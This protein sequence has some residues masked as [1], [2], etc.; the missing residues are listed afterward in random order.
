MNYEITIFNSPLF[1]AL[2]TSVNESGEPFFC[3]S[4]VCKVLNLQAG[5]TK[6]RLD[7]KGIN[8]INTLTDG[9]SQSMVYV[10]EPNLY[11]C[12]F[13]S[14]K[15][16][17]EMFQRWVFEEV[18]PSLRKNGGYMVAKLE[19][20]P[21]EIM[22]RALKIADEALLRRE[23]RIKEL[24]ADNDIKAQM[25]TAQTQELKGAAP[26]V[27]FYDDTLASV[28]YI[29]TS[30][31]ANELGMNTDTLNKK[32]ADAGIQHKQGKAW[33]VNKPYKNW[34]LHGTRT[35]GYTHND[36]SNGAKVYTV[37]KQR[38]RRF[39]HALYNNGFN[40]K[41]AIKEIKGDLSTE[42]T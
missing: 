21:E 20:T 37:W 16:T 41:L 31:I 19:D 2:R 13:R 14:N 29:T 1:G 4:D 10:N 28:D 23:H 32:L 8:L 9:G 12:I 25:I 34:N 5:A 42:K 3:L 39:I 35:F 33:L 30:Q 11:R 27:K 18:L 36:G 7:E 17:A 40:V 15:K 24:E 26:K 38:G 6:N 22:A